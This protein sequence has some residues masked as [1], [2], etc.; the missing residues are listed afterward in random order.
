MTLEA[1]G[2]KMRMSLLDLTAVDGIGAVQNLSD[3]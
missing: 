2:G 3:P 1:H